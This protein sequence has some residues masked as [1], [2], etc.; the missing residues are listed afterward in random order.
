VGSFILTSKERGPIT[1]FIFD[2]F[3]PF[4]QKN[5]VQLIQKTFVK[6]MCH[7]HQIFGNS[8]Y[9]GWPCVY[10]TKLKRKPLCPIDPQF[11]CLKFRKPWHRKFFKKKLIVKLWY[12]REMRKFT[13]FTL[14]LGLLSR[15]NTSFGGIRKVMNFLLKHS[16][17]CWRGIWVIGKVMPSWTWVAPL[18]WCFTPSWLLS[19]K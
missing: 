17:K 11:Q 8:S 3:L 19:A 9:G 5:P 12:N 7:W 6:K 10:I 4:G 18:I 15:P 2:E 1:R 16:I 13:I 14:S